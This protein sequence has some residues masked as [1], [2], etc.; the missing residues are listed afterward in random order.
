VA[1]FKY[2]KVRSY[3]PN[4]HTSELK[5]RTEVITNAHGGSLNVELRKWKLKLS[6]S[7]QK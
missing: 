3:P 6:I 1:S 5:C 7:E 2:K 4:E